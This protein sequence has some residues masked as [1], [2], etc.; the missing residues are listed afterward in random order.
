M[1]KYGYLL[2]TFILHIM[3]FLYWSCEIREFLQ[4]RISSIISI[5]QIKLLPR[6]IPIYT[7]RVKPLI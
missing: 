1:K 3:R 6:V 5:S 2:S 7:Y 4:Y